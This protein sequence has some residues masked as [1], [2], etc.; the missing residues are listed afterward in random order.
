[1][2]LNKLTS[3]LVVFATI[4]AMSLPVSTAYAAPD[5]AKIAER[6]ARKS[7]AV[8]EKV[9]KAIVKAYELYGQDKVNEAIAAL[10]GIEPSV[11]FDKAYLYSFL[12]K[13]Y[14]EKDPAKAQ[15]YLMD[16]VKLDVL[17]FGDQ[18]G[19][20]RNI[21]DLSLSDKK[22]QQ[23]LDYYNKWMDFTGETHPDVY[24]R[25]A[26]CY[27]EMKQYSKV[28]APADL[29]IAG[30]KVPKKEPYL[31]K[32]GAFYETKQIK[33]AIEVLE[34]V[35]VIFPEDKQWWVQ[36]GQFYN[37]DE[38]YGKAL[39]AVELAYKQGY[40]KTENEIKTLA[41]LYNNNSVPFRAGALL[42]KHMKA[43]LLKKDRS[44]L[45]SIAS[46]FNA[47]REFD[48]AA[49]YFG[50]LAKLENDGESYRRQGTALLMAGK[51]SAAVPAL[52]KALE[53]GVKDK[54]RVHIALMEAYFYQAKLKDAYRHNQ[55]A[56]DNG[57]AKAANSWAGYIRE[58]AEKK[59]ISL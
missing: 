44:T 58:R 57:Q 43:G 38:Q 22:Y 9:G 12:G 55:L 34:T 10:V 33:K 41:N 40:L 5:A 32:L 42:E 15:K 35:V 20:L 31:M 3:A 19:L 24:M 48:K 7:Q 39:A 29:A 1:M 26:N 50:E 28:I 51:E 17:S 59:G 2:K 25:M 46:S 11:P 56:R 47:A 45:A 16:A 36:L 54:G 13:L 23:A 30:Y 53:V 8:G 21:A 6:K 14:I 52:Q 27:Y 37:L 49:I 18:S 4:G